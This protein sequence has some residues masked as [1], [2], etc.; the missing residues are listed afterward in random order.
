MTKKPRT[1]WV[2]RMNLRRVLWER[3]ESGGDLAKAIGVSSSAAYQWLGGHAT[4]P[5]A[6]ALQMHELYGIEMRLQVHQEPEPRTAE[7]M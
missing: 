7:V 6:R 2:D 1:T 4:V 3:R 5:H